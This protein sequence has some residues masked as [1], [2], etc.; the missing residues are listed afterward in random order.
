MLPCLVVDKA[1]DTVEDSDDNIEIVGALI[2][3]TAVVA[4]TVVK[5]AFVLVEATL[6]YILVISDI[7]HYTNRL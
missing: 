1:V 3:S 4:S 7:L 2:T 5:A 6:C